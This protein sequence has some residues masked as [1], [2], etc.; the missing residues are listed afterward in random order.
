M[1]LLLRARLE[2]SS[3]DYFDEL[4]NQYGFIPENHL[5][6]INLRMQFFTRYVLAKNPADYKTPV[7]KDWAYVARR[8]FRYDVNARALC[9]A[10]AV[11]DVACIIRMYM[12]KKFVFWPFVPVFALTYLYRARS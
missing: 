4:Y 9:D 1:A 11:A 6:A 7:E 3:K 5:A 12:L 8:E 10:F 2:A